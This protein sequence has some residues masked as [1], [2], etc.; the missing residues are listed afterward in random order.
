MTGFLLA[1]VGH[2]D[3]RQNT[4]F[5]IVD[6][7]KHTSSQERIA[8]KVRP[9][10]I[11]PSQKKIFCVCS[12]RIAETTTKEIE[13]TFASFSQREDVA[14]IIIAQ[15]VANEIRHLIERYDKAIP[16]ILEIPAKDQPYDPNQDTML[17]RVKGLLGIQ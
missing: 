5:L 8:K 7:S 1:G 17:T 9:N 3:Y 6:T 13:S 11:P 15:N 2:K 16:A 4:N 14:I 12:H 10:F